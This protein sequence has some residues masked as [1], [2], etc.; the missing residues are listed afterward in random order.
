MGDRYVPGVL[1]VEM[2]SSGIPAATGNPENEEGET[3]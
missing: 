3:K 1:I 2:S